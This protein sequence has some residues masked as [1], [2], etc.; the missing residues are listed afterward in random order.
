[1]I[2]TLMQTISPLL[3]PLKSS[4]TKPIN[5]S[6][7]KNTHKIS[8]FKI[9]KFTPFYISHYSLNHLFTIGKIR[10]YDPPKQ[11]YILSPYHD[12]T[13]PLSV[14]P[15][16]LNLNDDFLLP[17]H[18]PTNVPKFF[19][20]MTKLVETALD[21]HSRSV[22]FIHPLFTNIAPLTNWLS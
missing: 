16:A 19:P 3:L 17:T 7:N 20:K 1:M 9:T 22:L 12:P 10:N 2:L 13:R 18:I 5:D 8:Y 11:Y 21:D 14:L 6:L 4:I 15:K